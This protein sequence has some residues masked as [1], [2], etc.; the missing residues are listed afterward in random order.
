VAA[1]ASPAAVASSLPAS[2]TQRPKSRHLEAGVEFEAV[3]IE[4][5]GEKR[6][7]DIAR[8]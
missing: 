2:L 3:E 4:E 5:N 7:I 8:L 1:A 6:V